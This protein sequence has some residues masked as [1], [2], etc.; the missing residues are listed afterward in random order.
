MSMQKKCPDKKISVIS[1]HGVRLHCL[2]L[3]RLPPEA[4]KPFS[5]STTGFSSLAVVKI[6]HSWKYFC[7]E[8]SNT[9]RKTH[10]GR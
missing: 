6:T 3:A 2:P 8:G 10:M 5:L 1:G 7:F 4:E 9:K